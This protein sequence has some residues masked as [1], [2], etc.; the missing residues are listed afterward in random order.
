MIENKRSRRTKMEIDVIKKAMK[1]LLIA[2]NPMTVRQLFYRLVCAYIVGKSEAQYKGTVGRL[3]T[4]MRLSGDLK[5]EWFADNTRWMRKPRSDSSITNSLY[6]TIEFYRQD[7]WENQDVYVEI[8]CEKDAIVG[9]LF[10]ITS[11]WDVPLMVTKGFCSVSFA[12][13]AAQMFKAVKKP[14]YIY[15][16]GDS[17][18]AGKRIYADLKSKL[19]MFAPG[20]NITFEKL[21]VTEQ[22]IKDLKLPTR[23]EKTGKGEC[24]EVDSIPPPI[25]RQIIE[26]AITKE[27]VKNNL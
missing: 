25:L 26:D 18:E 5:F 15:Y 12:H 14:V 11:R 2:E 10:P 16:L 7:I 27:Y 1:D 8:W 6:R 20:V 3:A 4:E 23:P 17:D 21:A 19:Q 24:T 13:E 22:Q 9:S